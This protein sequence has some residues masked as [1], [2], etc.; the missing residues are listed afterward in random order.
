VDG[1]V[2]VNHGLVRVRVRVLIEE[3]S[4]TPPVVN[5]SFEVVLLAVGVEHDGDG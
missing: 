5:S 3:G 2:R 1:A 4:Q